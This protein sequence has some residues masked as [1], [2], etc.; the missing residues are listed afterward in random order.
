VSREQPAEWW[1]AVSLRTKITGVTVFIVTAGLLVA[2]VGTM[3]VLRT[4]LLERVDANISAAAADITTWKIDLDQD[5]IARGNLVPTSFYMA[6]VSRSGD[7]V[8]DNL[9][10]DEQH[11]RPVLDQLT[12]SQVIQL[13]SAVTLQNATHTSQTRVVAFP[14]ENA[15][16]GNLATLVVGQRLDEVNATIARYTAIFLGFALTVVVL[17][18]AL[19]RVL[20]T[21]TFP[22]APRG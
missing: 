8:E 19:T 1:N 9:A 14:V 13:E 5:A 20:V 16:T 22:S 3:T 11:L 10:E 4:Y 12:L 7:L 15:S 21:S 17:S 2:G 18:A 6:L